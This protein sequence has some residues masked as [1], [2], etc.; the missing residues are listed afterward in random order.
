MRITN[1]SEPDS[2]TETN[3]D[4]KAG[5]R[6]FAHVWGDDEGSFIEMKNACGDKTTS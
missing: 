4:D 2:D 3:D 5:G 1:P 6:T